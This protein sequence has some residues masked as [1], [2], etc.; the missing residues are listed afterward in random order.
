MRVR[1]LIFDVEGTLADTEEVHRV[2]FNLAFERYRLGW[3]WSRAEYARLLAVTGG[4]ERLVA[5]IRALSMGTDQRLRLLALAPTVHDEKTKLY[6]SAIRDAAAPLRDGVVRLIAEALDAGCRVAVVSTTNTENVAALLRSAI[7]AQGASLFSAMVCGDQ[8][9]VRKPAP[10]IYRF[11]LR[12]LNVRPDEAIAFEDT[13]NGLR[14]ARAAGLRAV[15]ATPT[16]W[17]EDG[18]FSAAELV[19]PRLGDPWHPIAG[20]PGRGLRLH[21]WLSFDEL[22]NIGS[23]SA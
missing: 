19:L 1:A 2:A 16:P 15:V 5:Y 9:S 4:R 8:V 6:R 20:E 11:A 18:D 23:V 14:A 7:G 10:D 12:A 17:S 13:P 3:S 22:R 21:P